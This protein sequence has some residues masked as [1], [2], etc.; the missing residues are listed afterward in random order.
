MGQKKKSK[1]SIENLNLLIELEQFED[2]KEIK[3]KNDSFCPKI[4]I[5]IQ[6]FT[7]LYAVKFVLFTKGNKRAGVGGGHD[8]YNPVLPPPPPTPL[9]TKIAVN[10]D[11]I[12]I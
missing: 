11:F 12:L 2:T 8:S 1:M 4:I 3:K 6:F 10:N 5:F 7:H 9:P